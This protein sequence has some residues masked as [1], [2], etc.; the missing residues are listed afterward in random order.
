MRV[1]HRIDQHD[2]HATV[3]IGVATCPDHGAD[4]DTLLQRADIALADAKMRG[5][6]TYRVYMPRMTPERAQSMG[7]DQTA[8]KAVRGYRLALLQL[9]D[10]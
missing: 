6:G 5:R 1:P 2:V 10:R 3:S 4:A 7:T 8:G 9:T